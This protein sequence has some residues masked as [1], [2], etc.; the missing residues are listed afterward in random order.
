MK[1]VSL[2][3]NK[4]LFSGYD[5]FALHILYIGVAASFIYPSFMIRSTTGSYLYPLAVWVVVALISAFVYRM[6]L[7]NLNGISLVEELRASIGVWFASA[8]CLPLLLAVL[9]SAITILRAYSEIMTMTMLPTT[10]IFFLNGLLIAPV[11]LSYAGI[12]PIIRSAKVFFL[13]AIIL[14][15]ALQLVGISDV[16]WHLGQPWFTT[17]GDFFLNRDFYAGSFLWMGFAISSMLG[18]YTP[19]AAR[20]AW[21]SYALALL[22]SIPAIAGFFY[23][24]VLTFGREFSRQLTVPFVSKMDSIYH[25]W[26][27]VD[28]LAALFVSAVML[29]ILIVLAIKQYFLEYIIRKLMPSADRRLLS[30]LGFLLV[31]GGA[32]W[33][34]SWRSMEHFLTLGVALRGYVLILFPLLVMAA[35]HIARRRQKAGHSA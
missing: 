11:L 14:C 23:F 29:H 19:Q 12:M 15:W 30:I 28:N 2:V 35:L 3:K 25:Y 10:P 21:R 8:L 13:V 9:V 6:L 17:T 18:A 34:P 4:S 31:Y 33:L 1:G 27:I 20:M 26:I 16:K 7:S 22:V 5:L 32:T 24:P